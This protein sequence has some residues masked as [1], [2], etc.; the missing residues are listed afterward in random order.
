MMEKLSVFKCAKC[1]NIVEVMHVGGGVL[2]CCG[3]PMK[4][5]KENSTDAAQEKHVPVLDGEM[6]KVGSA[7]H[8]MAEDHYIEWIEV[9]NGDRVCRKFLKPG[10]EPAAEFS[11]AKAGSK[12]R[13]FCNKH[14]LWKAEI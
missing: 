6:V 13:E 2:T 9:I 4:E 11:C 5:L 14:G 7:A 8:P 12:L 10:E 1:G 3:E